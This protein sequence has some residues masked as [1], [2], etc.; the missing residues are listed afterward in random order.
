MNTETKLP[1]G[2]DAA[3]A[4]I[5]VALDHAIFDEQRKQCA[6][7]V[8]AIRSEYAQRLTLQHHAADQA[9]RVAD[10]EVE[11]NKL[12]HEHHLVR[13]D[14]QAR[15]DAAVIRALSAE[16][17]RD[18]LRARLA[19]L[20]RQEPICTVQMT[21]TGGRLRY[22]PDAEAL[23]EHGMPLYARPVPAIPAGWRL[24]PVEPTR[25]MLGAVVSSMDDF[26]L[27]DG[28]ENQYRADWAAMIAA[29][30]EAAR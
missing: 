25:E 11:R 27:G 3:V 10:L 24:V 4:L 17:E 28:A 20:D 14:A 16:K 7:A 13:A 22:N 18:E 15:V 2:L 9:Q 12:A 19:E 6:D 30:P 29:A 23:P 26:L 5:G 8:D 21:T 1:D